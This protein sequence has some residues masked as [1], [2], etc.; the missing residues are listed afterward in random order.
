MARL[1]NDKAKHRDCRGIRDD[2]QGNGATGRL[3]DVTQ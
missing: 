2:R 1:G 3:V